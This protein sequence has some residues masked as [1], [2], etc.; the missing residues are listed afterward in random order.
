MKLPACTLTLAAVCGASFANAQTVNP[1]GPLER[2][3]HIVIIFQENRTPDNLFQGLCVPPFGSAA[4][5]SPHP[6]PGQYDIQ[7]SHWLDKNSATDGHRQ[8]P[9]QVA[10]LGDSDRC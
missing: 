1:A 3:Q 2:F 10:Q 4:S 7:V 8:L 5:C 6:A 9:A